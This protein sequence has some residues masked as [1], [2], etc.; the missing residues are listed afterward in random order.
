M[1]PNA[2]PPW[3]TD[4]IEDLKYIKQSVS[5]IDKIEKMVDRINTKVETL[6]T[7]VKNN[8]ARVTEVEQSNQFI[9]NEF[10][11]TKKKITS[12]SAEIKKLSIR[13]TD[14]EET[15]SKLETQNIILEE[16]CNDLESRS[17]RENLL[18]HGFDESNGEECE[19]VIKDFIANKL[20]IDT[21]ITLDRTHRLGRPKTTGPRPIVAK[22]HEYKQ[23]ELV[24]TTSITKSAALRDDHQS[25]GIQQ[26]KA[27][28]QKR[29]SMF[30][31]MERE[32]AAGKFVKWAG[33][34][35]MVREAGGNFREFTN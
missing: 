17:M 23:R 9:S 30:P 8:D 15:V 5:T 14:F 26:T 7:K 24:R 3:A 28:L 21:I 22:F 25:V 33:A 32:R 11:E 35:L 13:C 4:I 10:E 20:E 19:Q 1:A 6:E 34:K 31:L 18:F 2:T 12:A 29:R 16:K 27:I